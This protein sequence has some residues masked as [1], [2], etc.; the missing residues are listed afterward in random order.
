MG[1]EGENGGRSEAKNKRHSQDELLPIYENSRLGEFG[2]SLL[3]S[4]FVFFS[5]G[6][7]KPK[8]RWRR[9]HSVSEQL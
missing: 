4:W 6:V 1:W 3:V 2:L 9:L 7:E 8:V 5:R